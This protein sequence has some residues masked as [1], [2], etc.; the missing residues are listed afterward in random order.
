MSP[1]GRSNISPILTLGWIPV[2]WQIQLAVVHLPLRV[3]VSVPP[4]WDRGVLS[5][6]QLPRY[7]DGP[8]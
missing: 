5:T 6:D 7:D 4:T 3:G 2:F 1:P 8:W